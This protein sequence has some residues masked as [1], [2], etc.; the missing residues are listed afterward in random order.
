[1][2][3]VDHAHIGD[4]AAIGVIHGV[5][6]HGS[7]W[8]RGI[9]YRRRYVADDL[10][11]QAVFASQPPRS[12]LWGGHIVRI[13]AHASLPLFEALSPPT[14]ERLSANGLVVRRMDGPIGAASAMKLSYAGITKGCTAIGS[15]MML[16]ATR[17]GIATSTERLAQEMLAAG[18]EVAAEIADDVGDLPAEPEREARAEEVQAA[19]VRIRARVEAPD[20]WRRARPNLRSPSVTNRRRSP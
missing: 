6:D 12:K 7:R 1:M 10:L 4:D 2:R 18:H 16:G 5:E 19:G 14:I 3:A 9:S 20:R 11:E 17:G 15:A 8:R 13:C